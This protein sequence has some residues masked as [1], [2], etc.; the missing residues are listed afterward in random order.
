[1]LTAAV[2]I[3]GAVETDIGRVV[4]GYDL[5][6]GV[7]RDAGFKGRQFIQALPAIIERDARFRLE[8]PA[9]VR[10]RAPAPPPLALNGDREFRERRRC[11][12]RFGG[13]RDRRVLEGMRGCTAHAWKVARLENKSRTILKPVANCGYPCRDRPFLRPIRQGALPSYPGTMIRLRSRVR[14]ERPSCLRSRA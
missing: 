7:E 10:M 12:R 5:S 11:T 6:G 13:R 9:G 4:A 1:M 14:E 2:G 3:D 8:A